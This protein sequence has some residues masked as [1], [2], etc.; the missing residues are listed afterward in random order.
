MQLS[1]KLRELNAWLLWIV[2]IFFILLLAAVSAY[3]IFEEKYKN[4]IYPGIHI[5]NYQLGGLAVAEAQKTL[6]KIIDE[7]SQNGIAFRLENTKKVI[8]PVSPSPANDLAIQ[9]VEFDTEQTIDKAYAFGREGNFFHRLKDIL[10][11][12]LFK[13]PQAMFFS[14][15]SEVLKKQLRENFSTYEMAAE[16]AK[17]KMEGDDIFATEEKNGQ[18]ID[19]EKAAKEMESKLLTLDR[20]DISLILNIDYPKVHKN[21][22]ISIE[23]D[24]KNILELAPIIIMSATG[25]EQ[26]N[27]KIKKW[28]VK[29]SELTL[30][31]ISKND[32]DGRPS[33]SLYTD[34]VKEFLD[35]KVAPD[36]NIE[37]QEA[38]FNIAGGK[39]AKFQGGRDGFSIKIN[40]TISKIER[41]LLTERKKEI[42][43]VT[44]VVKS[45]LKAGDVNDLGIK[46]IIGTGQSNFAG[47][48]SNRRHNIR[49]GAYSV[50]GTLIKPGQ[51]FSLL[52]TLGKIDGSTGYKTELVIKENKTT[53]EFGGGLCQI[54]TTVFRGALASGLPITARQN[55]SY[56]VGYYE[57]AGTDATIYDPQPDFRFLNDTGH[58]I[59]IQTRLSGNNIYFDFWG[60]KDGRQVIRT[61]P[62]IYNIVKPPA[63]KRI[64]TLTLKPGEKKCTEKSHN[65]ADAYFDYKVTYADGTVKSKRFK[66][67]YVPWQEVCLIGVEKLSEPIKTE[68][69]VNSQNLIDS[70]V[71]D[72]GIS[73][74]VPSTDK[75]TDQVLTPAN[76]VTASTTI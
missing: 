55:H 39:V 50:N 34:K 28:E 57:P 14:I 1:P 20:S 12:T 11:T 69:A 63:G 54:G 42:E 6:N 27:N 16:D 71:P 37:L 67:H 46:E 40:D 5:G 62:T 49:I 26:K 23:S 15:N 47:S 73:P 25:T 35:K 24:A 51:E 52:R 18:A 30:W 48:P 9:T 60:T 29:K 61:K 19:Y 72:Q 53:P 44:E 32:P 74:S 33:L 45:T 22:L 31:L 65:G 56:R 66:S 2:A 75:K 38:K 13:E 76:T 58:H 59:L 3:F 21:D 17:L 36:V 10:R 4:K 68:S 70:K 41:E 8:Y 7:I 43:L 64:E